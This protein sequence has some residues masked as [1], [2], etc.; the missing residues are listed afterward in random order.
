MACVGAAVVVVAVITLLLRLRQLARFHVKVTLE[1]AADVT[2]I[3]QFG[4]SSGRG[5]DRHQ[6]PLVWRA[7]VSL[8]FI[9]DYHLTCYFT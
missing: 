5:A 6:G 1:Q 9:H 7:C 8:P 4:S 2:A 3:A